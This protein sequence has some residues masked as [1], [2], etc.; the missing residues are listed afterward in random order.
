MNFNKDSEMESQ[1][2]LLAEDTKKQK[3]GLNAT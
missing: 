1:I 2:K 3:H